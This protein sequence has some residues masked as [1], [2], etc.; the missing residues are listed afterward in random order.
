M[1]HPIFR[2]TAMALAVLASTAMAATERPLV[3]PV[4]AWVQ[5]AAQQAAPAPATDAAL[6][7]LLNDEQRLFSPQAV[8]TYFD[9]RVRIQTPQG[10]QAVGTV[11]LVWQPDADVITVHRLLVRRGS[12]VR[13]L[14]GDGSGF[15]ILR[16]ED[17]LEQSMLTGQLTAILQPSDLQVGDI[18]EFAYTHRHADPVVPDKPDVQLAWLNTPIQTVRFRATWPKQMDIRW[19]IR[20]FKPDLQESTSGDNRSI[21]FTLENPQPLLQP[22][23]A[24]PR[25]AAMRRMELSA[26]RTWSDVSRRLAPLYE[27]SSRLAPDSPLRG[28]IQR[29]RDASSDPKVRAAA[30]LRL[31]Q[32]Q[33]RYVLLA[34]DQ[35]AL[36]PATADQTWQRRYG[37]CKAKTALLLALFRE[38]GIE[39]DP[40]AVNS[41]MGDNIER[42]LPGISAFDHVLV[43][44]TIAGRTYWLDGTRPADRQIDNL[45]V[46]SYSWGLPLNARGSELVRILPAPLGEPQLVHEVSLDAS[47]GVDAAVPF[48]ASAVFRGDG[49]LGVKLS[50]DNLES[51]QREQGM[52]NYWRNRFDRLQLSKVS[53][54]YD[55]ARNTLTWN[56]EGTLR[57]EWDESG[58]F[59][60]DGMRLG[61]KADFTRP[62]GTDAEAPYAVS[63][64]EY[65]VTRVSVKL[66]TGSSRFTLSGTNIER[67]LAGWEYKRQASIVD[68]LFS[69][70]SSS[71]SV[72]AEI[73]ARD[74]RAAEAGL[75]EIYKNGLYIKKPRDIPSESE[76]RSSAGKPLDTASA[77]VVRGFDMMNRS[78]YEPAI[79]EFTSAIQLDPKNAIAYAD[80]GLSYFNLG[81]FEAARPDLHKA[82][83]LDAANATVLRGLGAMEQHDGHTARALELLS[84]SLQIEDSTWA[85]DQRVAAYLASRDFG[86]AA[87]DLARLSRTAANAIYYFPK[88]A[89]GLLQQNRIDDIR[90]LAQASLDARAGASDGKLGAAVL[91]MI[92]GPRDR[93]RALLDEA[94]AAA[95]SAELYTQRAFTAPSPE[96][97]I[98]DFEQALRLDPKHTPAL[99]QMSQVQIATRKYPE[100]L[101]TLD[102]LE[103]ASAPTFSTRILRGEAHARLGQLEPAKENYA[104]ARELAKGN[105]TALNNLC[106]NQGLVGISL[107][108]AL[109]DCDGA[110]AAAP[111]VP[112][113]ADSR[114]LVLLKLGRHAEA[115]ASYDAALAKAPRLAASLYGRGIA[116]QRMGL[117]AEGTADL[118]AA[119]GIEPAIEARFASYGLDTIRQPSAAPSV[120]R[121]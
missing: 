83:E 118:E 16:R 31:V 41:V 43:R 19:Q 55:E 56:A 6:Q 108:D 116:K 64:P 12:Q 79:A 119:R 50:Y 99:Q 17:M 29:I 5:P 62:E 94:I 46:P 10:L 48:R 89:M 87:Q 34:M 63:Y 40:V 107:E 111:A 76:L 52:R 66:P 88:H 18:L 39:A 60:V 59:E 80:R 25:Y 85:R 42:L 121:R 35:G 97:S 86:N 113:F 54:A 26:F 27:A 9:S 93:A 36:V 45:R 65:S 68:S 106:W 91:F 11:A 77:Y 78:M 8:D 61:F 98:A 2:A 120:P 115:V 44:S 73:S 4:P 37:D 51:T 20:D 90:A 30:A 114:G 81:R 47:A 22:S 84:K 105:A 96:S 24:P 57:M 1:Q 75:R 21:A 67:T 23:G 110:L 14:L 72:V 15:T 3:G 103:A 7:I 109:K 49:A 102:R 82:F 95:P 100:A 117:Q 101:Q 112:A 104:A 70:E 74:A 69:A 38:L 53:S 92:A 58:F 32:E 13:D 71:R 33:V 28:E